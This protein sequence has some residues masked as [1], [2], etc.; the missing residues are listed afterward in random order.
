MN[1]KRFGP[2]QGRGRESFQLTLKGAGVPEKSVSPANGK[3]IAVS[4]TA[5][6]PQLIDRKD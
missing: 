5:I 4:I 3:G 2:S 1:G 6:H